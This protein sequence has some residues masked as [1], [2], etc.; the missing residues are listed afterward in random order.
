MLRVLRNLHLQKLQSLLNGK[1]KI[2]L[3]HLQLLSRNLFRSLLSLKSLNQQLRSY[4]RS[5]DIEE[6]EKRWHIDH[7]IHQNTHTF[8]SK[9]TKKHQVTRQGV[10]I[11]EVPLPVSPTSKKQ[12]AVNMSKKISKKRQKFIIEDSQED[13][14]V[15]KSPL[16]ETNILSPQKNSQVKSNLEETRNSGGNVETSIVDTTT[17]LGES[18]KVLTPEQTVVMPPVVS[19]ENPKDQGNSILIIS[20][21]FNTSTVSTTPTVTHS[22]TFANILN[23]PITSLFSSQSTDPPITREEEEDTN[24]DDNE[25]DGTLSNIEFVPKEENIPDNMLLTD[26]QFKILNRKLNLIL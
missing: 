21:S 18:T 17:N 7:L 10:L 3:R 11:R 4:L 26:K 6:I 25:F 19:N 13:I 24:D 23:K 2:T 9:F 14:V 20:P 22:Q 8:S 5:L 15:S 16:H 1:S 12:F